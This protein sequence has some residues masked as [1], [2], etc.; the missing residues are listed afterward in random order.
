MGAARFARILVRILFS[1]LFGA[2]VCLLFALVLSE[3]S[4]ITWAA[5]LLWIRTWPNLILVPMAMGVVAAYFWRSLSLRTS[6]YLVWWVVT[7]LVAPLGA[8]LIWKEG[9]VCLL[10]GFPIL[11]VSGF[12]GV[13]LGRVWFGSKMSKMNL[14]IVPLLF[15]AILAEGEFRIERESVMTDRVLVHAAP[16][17]VWKHVIAFPPIA[18]QPNYWLNRLGL[19][20]P[21]ATTCDG[22]FVG[23][24][25]RCIFTNDLI[26]REKV[27]RIVPLRLFTFDIIEQPPDPELLGHL[28]LHRGQFEL[29]DNGDG[30]TTLTRRSWYTLH[31][32]PLWYFDWWTRQITSRVHLRVM[33]H[34]KR[35]SEDS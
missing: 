5:N 16:A 33:E 11:F 22:P 12:G 3:L 4:Q 25:R 32:R 34:I 24:D 2:V 10:V 17:E 19:P 20:S 7:S 8:Y 21:L 9:L 23:A 27:S 1:N 18:E 15:L 13:I 29:T 35:L 14:S 28:A 26:F 6:Q 30:T 31:M